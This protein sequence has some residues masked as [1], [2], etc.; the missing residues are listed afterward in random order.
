MT[1]PVGHLSLSLWQRT[2]LIFLFFEKAD[3]YF[4]LHPE[5][6]TDLVVRS[7][8]SL[9]AVVLYSGIS[10]E[11]FHLTVHKII[12]T[13][14]NGQNIPAVKDVGMSTVMCFLKEV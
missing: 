1:L 5:E 4:S 6:G 12:R 13:D 8:R 14:E 11:K 7:L 3:L 9:K 10:F 2:K